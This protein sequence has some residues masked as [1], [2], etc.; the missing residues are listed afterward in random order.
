MRSRVP[1]LMA[2]S[3]AVI[4]FVAVQATPVHAESILNFGLNN[5][6]SITATETGGTSTT[7]TT[8]GGAQSVTITLLNGAA[9]SISAYL[10]LTAT[11]VG[12]AV[13]FQNSLY[14]N[15][16]GSFTITA[17]ANGSGVNYLSGTFTNVAFD[18]KLSGLN[19]GTGAT[20]SADDPT[21]K[22]V[23]TSS[24]ITNLAAPSTASF[25][26]SDV[27][28]AAP[29]GVNDLELQSER[30]GH[31]FGQP[32]WL[33][34]QP[35][36]VDVRGRRPGSAGHDRLWPATTQGSGRLSPPCQTHSSNEPDPNEP[37]SFSGQVLSPRRRLPARAFVSLVPAVQRL[38]FGK[39]GWKA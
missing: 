13:V 9:A 3:V 11:S 32:R 5:S 38:V 8:T 18:S 37:D 39:S 35:G 20:L 31:V 22:I 10:N 16:N 2:A 27:N 29:R 23:F 19:G 1:T 25:T 15:F 34:D 7:I 12:P 4:V 33:L 6:G 26:F 36:A 14:Q 28:P 24:V 21:A 30:I 17:N